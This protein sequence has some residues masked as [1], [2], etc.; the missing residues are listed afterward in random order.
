MGKLQ[1]QENSSISLNERYNKKLAVLKQYNL[2]PLNMT[3]EDILEERI[4]KN[5]F[6]EENELIIN[7][8]FVAH[9][10]PIIIGGLGFG[11]S[12]GLRG[13]P[14]L[15]R[16]AGNIF[17]AGF[18]VVGG[19]FCFDPATATPYFLYS[20]IY[21]TWAGFIAGFVGIMLFVFDDLIPIPMFNFYSNFFAMGLAGFTF[22][23]EASFLNPQ[24]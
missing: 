24:K 10:A 13:F 5:T 19:V 21:P 1:N 12:I 22:W 11:V 18:I 4:I 7:Q 20:L 6:S 2:V 14:L 15:K 16:I 3:V 23:A 9:L 8:P 17:F